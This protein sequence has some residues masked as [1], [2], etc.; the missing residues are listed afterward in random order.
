VDRLKRGPCRGCQ[1]NHVMMRDLAWRGAAPSLVLARRGRPFPGHL[2]MGGGVGS[3][4]R[5]VVQPAD[6][7]LSLK[8]KK[9]V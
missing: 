5:F 6:A 3:E 9:N 4:I 7:A 2:G 1:S 8:R